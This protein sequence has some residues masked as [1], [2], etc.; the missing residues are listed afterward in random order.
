MKKVLIILGG[1]LLTVIVVLAGAVWWVLIPMRFAGIDRDPARALADPKEEWELGRVIDAFDISDVTS[2]SRPSLMPP[3]RSSRIIRDCRRCMATSLGISPISRKA[4]PHSAIPTALNFGDD[5]NFYRDRADTHSDA[6]RHDEALADI[7]AALRLAPD[8]PPLLVAKMYTLLE[9]GKQDKVDELAALVE[10]IDPQSSRLAAF[11]TSSE[12]L[13]TYQGQVE[14]FARQR[15]G[16]HGRSEESVRA[17]RRA[18]VRAIAKVRCT[19]SACALT[20]A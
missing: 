15:S 4:T 16:V 19:L 1:L 7:D 6:K 3:I 10:A 8:S 5:V 12:K 13:A 11:K 2:G 17:W 20:L 9:L 14:A 18:R